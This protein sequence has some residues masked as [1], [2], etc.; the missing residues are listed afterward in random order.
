MNSREFKK[1]ILYSDIY[2]NLYIMAKLIKFKFQEQIKSIR[3]KPKIN[4][5]KIIKK[6]YI[7]PHDNPCYIG[8][9]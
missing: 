1:L 6:I 3:I 7:L 2:L 9:S 4:V 5:S 8:L